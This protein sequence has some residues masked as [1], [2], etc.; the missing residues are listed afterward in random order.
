MSLNFIGQISCVLFTVAYL[1]KDIIWLRAISII[2]SFGFI[3]FNY[4][5]P[6]EPIWLVIH[7][8]TLWIA[9]NS[10]QLLILIKE[11][12]F[13]NLTPEERGLHDSLLPTLSAL[14]FDKILSC[15]KWRTVPKG[16]FII[17]ENDPL[18]QQLLNIAKNP[19]CH[20]QL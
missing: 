8:N 12:V 4:Y 13:V 10:V 18:V 3:I 7:W 19:D 6:P 20:N 1:V 14:E 17:K 15:S 11:R 2:G 16:E 5:F 9:I